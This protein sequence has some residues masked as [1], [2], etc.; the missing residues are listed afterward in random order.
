MKFLRTAL[1]EVIIVEPDLHRD[2]RGFFLETYHGVKYRDGGIA[3]S[4]VQD[5]HSSSTRGTVRGLHAQLRRPQGKLVRVLRGEVYD[6]A[7][8]IRRGS[9]SFLHWIGVTLSAENFRQCYV[10]PGFAHGFCVTS[11]DAEV[12]YKCT[13]YYDPTAEIRILWSDPAI[14]IEWPVSTPILSDQ[15]RAGQRVAEVMDQLPQFDEPSR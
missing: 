1:P 8:D 11:D 9:P 15:D 14:G 13:D 12:E 7:V 2:G 6:V 10:P 3:V 4:F 5:N